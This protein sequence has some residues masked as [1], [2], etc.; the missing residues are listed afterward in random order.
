MTMRGHGAGGLM[1]FQHGDFAEAWTRFR[2]SS[3]EF[4]GGQRYS[5]E[6]VGGLSEARPVTV[7]C[8]APRAHDEQLAPGLR[9]IGLLRDQAYDFAR[10]RA[11]TAEIAPA[12]GICRAV[13][14]PALA[15]MLGRGV[16]VLPL[17][18]DGLENDGLRALWRNLRLARLLMHP[19]VPGVC[20]HSLNATRSLHRAIRYPRARLAPWDWAPLEAD[21]APRRA[22]PAG[23]PFTIFYAGAIVEAKGVGDCLAALALLR[24][25]GIDV[26]MSFAGRGEVEAMQ[27]QARR[28][29]VA[30]LAT[31]L[32]PRP[33]AE[34]QALM[35]SHDAVAVP[36]RRSYPEGLPKTLLEGLAAR[37]ATIVSDHP[38]FADRVRDGR[39][40]AMFAGGDPAA[41]ADAVA[42]LRA[43]P[44]LYE[45][46]SRAAPAAL[47]RM[48]VGMRW[49]RAIEL[50]LE[51]PRNRS[52][53]VQAHSLVE[54]EKRLAAG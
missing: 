34:V 28:L 38:A 6:V 32:G 25:R 9:S 4:Y 39:D 14:R 15:A 43:D 27:A 21:A 20:N 12:L 37:G 3:E 31:F 7:V 40:V 19:L 54:V 8:C 33:S 18:A 44:A 35:R 22:P 11:L 17:L 36:S 47:A 53:W 13:A 16:P 48:Y 29:G 51:D 30:E 49:H 10:L 2:R 50:F 24:G 23:R 5:V 41:L 52:R 46:L 42:R 26:R 1:I 45:T